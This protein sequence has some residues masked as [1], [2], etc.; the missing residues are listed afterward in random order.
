MK[1]KCCAVLSVVILFYVKMF[2]LEFFVILCTVYFC[3]I[4]CSVPVH[5][6][7]A[8]L[9]VQEILHMF[10]ELPLLFF[11]IPTA[12]SVLQPAPVPIRWFF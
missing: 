12:T 9:L 1:S 11:F 4:M 7:P 3:V 6:L 8:I 5:L 2:S 10:L